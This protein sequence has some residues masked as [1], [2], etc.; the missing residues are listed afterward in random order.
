VANGSGSP[1]CD[2]GGTGWRCAVD[3]SCSSP[4]TLTGQVFDPAGKNPLYNASVF[5][6]NVVAGLP[7]IA[8]GTTAGCNTCDAPIGDYVVA[9]QTAADGTFTLTN[10]PSG[11][12]V[13]VTVQMGKWRATYTVSTTS[14]QTTTVT[15]GTLHLPR[16][17]TQGDMPQMALVTG[18]CDDMACFLTGIGIDPLEFGAPQS[19]GRVDVYQGLGLSGNGASLS[20]GT[21]GSCTASGSTSCVWNS[22]SNLQNYD[23]MMLSCECGENLQTKPASAMTA[24]RTWLDNGGKVFASH[25]QYTWFQD[26]PSADFQN[27][28][29]WLGSSVAVGGGSGYSYDINNI[30]A[31]GSFSKGVSFGEWLGTVGAL[32]VAG[33]PDTMALSNVGASVSTVNPTT[34]QEWIYD[35]EANDAGLNDVKF[36]SFETPIGGLTGDAA[37]TTSTNKY[38]GKAVFTDLHTGGS[39]LAEYDSVPAECPTGVTLTNQQKALEF[40]FFDL[41]AC[42]ADDSVAPPPPP[43]PSSP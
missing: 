36:L 16:N 41:S 6:P 4:T 42:V 10:V 19:G 30:N 15:A 13:P 1:G 27:V 22:E 28:A 12:D 18:G 38:C 26:N 35:S 14:C 2:A 39:L 11:T 20:S 5:V 17:R 7:S 21:A 23:I 31:I 9:T 40:L 8:T 32:T 3:T 24:L 34:T 37:P 43:P 25:F 29:T 33:M